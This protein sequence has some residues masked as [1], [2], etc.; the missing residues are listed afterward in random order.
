MDT[1]NVF[2]TET[3]PHPEDLWN[4]TRTYAD[5]IVPGFCDGFEK[6]KAPRLTEEQIATPSPPKKS[7]IIKK[8]AKEVDNENTNDKSFSKSE[9]ESS[10]SLEKQQSITSPKP[11]SPD[12]NSPPIEPEV[13]ICEPQLE[14]VLVEPQSSENIDNSQPIPSTSLSPPLPSQKQQNSNESE[15][16]ITQKIELIETTTEIIKEEEKSTIDLEKINKIELKKEKETAV[17]VTVFLSYFNTSLRRPR[18]ANLTAATF[19]S[20][21]FFLCVFV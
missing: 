2:S 20:I 4:L 18:F 6:H 1:M 15:S 14:E 9:N 12:N 8:V 10:Q 16:S 11:P 7:D 21:S 3:N 5:T 19:G 13:I 17:I